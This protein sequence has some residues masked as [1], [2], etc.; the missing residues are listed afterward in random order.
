MSDVTANGSRIARPA[1]P[2]PAG[3]Y[4]GTF[5]VDDLAD[6]RRLA[7]DHGRHA[8]LSPR[9]VSDF[10][11]AVNEI[12]TNAIRHG[13]QRARLRLWTTPNGAHCEVYGGRWISEEHPSAIRLDDTDSL[14]L[15]LVWQIC[16]DVALSHGPGG[17]TVRL[18]V[19]ASERG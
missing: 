6:V 10:V 14:R 12:A 18:S 4:E 15:W 8:G 5:S 19:D 16:S 1:A 13:C 11:L 3:R 2:A 7:A 9:R 17:T